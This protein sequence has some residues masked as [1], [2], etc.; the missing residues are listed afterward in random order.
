M[1]PVKPGS[2]VKLP[3][4]TLVPVKYGNDILMVPTMPIFKE[5]ALPGCNCPICQDIRKEN[6]QI[7]SDIM[8][9]ASSNNKIMIKIPII[10]IPPDFKKKK[11]FQKIP[12]QGCNCPICRN[13]RNQ[14]L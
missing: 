13:L 8:N 9:N 7:L 6:N 10:I 5:N 12:L 3:P 2:I 14:E 4:G 11:N 1:D